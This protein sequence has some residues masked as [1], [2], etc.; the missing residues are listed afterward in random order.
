MFC[1][2]KTVILDDAS[3]EVGSHEF[4]YIKFEPTF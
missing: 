2:K 1:A 3:S 4:S